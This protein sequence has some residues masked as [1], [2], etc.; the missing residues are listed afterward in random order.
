M[1]FTGLFSRNLLGILANFKSFKG[2]GKARKR[3]TKIFI[4][5]LCIYN[6]S[7]VQFKK[8][9]RNAFLFCLN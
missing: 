3:F 1:H 6:H 2:L 8:D 9:N 7:C 4:K 5:F